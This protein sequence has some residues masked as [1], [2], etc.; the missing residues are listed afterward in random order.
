MPLK[1]R[2]GCF[3]AFSVL[4]GVSGKFIWTHQCVSASLISGFYGASRG[5]PWLLRHCHNINKSP[6]PAIVCLHF[7]DAEAPLRNWKIMTLTLFYSSILLFLSF[8]LVTTQ[9]LEG[10]TKLTFAISDSNIVMS[11]NP[12]FGFPS[13]VHFRFQRLLVNFV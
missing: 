9:R 3:A 13:M 2:G 4:L 10:K 8:R 6:S 5:K 1:Y 7:D 12:Q 11:N